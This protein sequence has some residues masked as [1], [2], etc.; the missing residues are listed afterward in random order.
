MV[1]GMSKDKSWSDRLQ[2]TRQHD[3]DEIESWMAGSG[4]KVLAGIV[5]L[6]VLWFIVSQIMNAVA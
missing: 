5:I 2:E 3:K 4:S 1:S 6:I